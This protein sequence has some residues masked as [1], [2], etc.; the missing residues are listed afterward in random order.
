M[1]KRIQMTKDDAV[2]LF[3]IRMRGALAAAFSHAGLAPTDAQWK[4]LRG[5]V[6]ITMRDTGEIAFSTVT[7]FSLSFYDRRAADDT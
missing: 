1:N 6:E 5:Q 2:E 4:M 3:E 7:D